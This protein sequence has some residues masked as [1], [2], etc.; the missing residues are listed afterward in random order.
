MLEPSAK[1]VPLVF[2]ET[3]E[4][5]FE[6]AGVLKVAN[7]FAGDCKELSCAIDLVDSFLDII[8]NVNKVIDY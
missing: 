4:S 7:L 8:S 2:N 6:M 3:E 1:V 5:L